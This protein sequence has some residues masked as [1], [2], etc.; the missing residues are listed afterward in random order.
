MCSHKPKEEMVSLSHRTGK[1]NKP[2]IRTKRCSPSNED[3]SDELLILDIQLVL[4][5]F[6]SLF[7]VNHPVFR[8]A[9]YRPI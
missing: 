1:E 5:R 3:P 2:F 7:T 6:C 8:T 9:K 4:K